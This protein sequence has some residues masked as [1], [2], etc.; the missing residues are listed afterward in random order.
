MKPQI[1]RWMF[2][3]LAFVLIAG[4][5]ST[6]ETEGAADVPVEVRNNLIPPTSLTVWMVPTVGGRDMLGVVPP[7]ATQ[8][9]GFNMFSASGEYRLQAQTTAGE[10][11]WSYPFILSESD[12]A[13]IWDL[14]ANNIQVN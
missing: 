8:T 14:S 11:I 7:G 13:V 10:E 1:Q 5:A 2:A 4:C 6:S 3:L 9:L 12:A